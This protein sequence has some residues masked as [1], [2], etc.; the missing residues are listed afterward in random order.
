MEPDP[1]TWPAEEIR[2]YDAGAD[3]GTSDYFTNAIVGHEGSSRTDYIGSEDDYLIMQD[4]AEDR[5][6]LGYVGYTYY[7]EYRAAGCSNPS[8]S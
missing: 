8:S 7:Y 3:S 6:A 1:P 2:L 5:L 4:M